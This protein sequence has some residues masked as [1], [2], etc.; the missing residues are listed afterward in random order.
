MLKFPAKIKNC[1]NHY[2]AQINV[3][4][5]RGDNSCCHNESN[6]K[7]G[8]LIYIVYETNLTTTKTFIRTQYWSTSFSSVLGNRETHIPYNSNSYQLKQ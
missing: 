7:Y 4:V 5:D 8:Y 6:G 3:P 2:S 1:R